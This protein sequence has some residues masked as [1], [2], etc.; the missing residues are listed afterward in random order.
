MTCVSCRWQHVEDG[1]EVILAKGLSKE[2]QHWVEATGRLLWDTAPALATIL[3]AKPL[4]LTNKRIVELGC[5]ATTICKVIASK[6]AT[7][8]VTT[9]G[10]LSSMELLQ[11]TIL[12]NSETF[13]VTEVVCRKLE[14]C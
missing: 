2:N 6:F 10:D 14:R 13:P 4:L 1:T 3:N 9:D 11:E 12:F 7:T 5:G 8:I